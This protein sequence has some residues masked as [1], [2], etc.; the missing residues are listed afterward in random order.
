MQRGQMVYEDYPNQGGPERGWELASGTKSFSGVMAAAAVQDGL[1]DLDERAGETLREWRSDARKRRITIRQILT[2]TSGL[3]GGRLGRPPTYAAAIAAP[4]VAAPGESFSYGPSPFQVF[5]EI[6]RRKTNADPLEYL[7]RRILDPLSIRPTSWRRGAD[8][9]SHLP[10]GAHIIARDWARFGEF[11]LRGGDG[12]VDART[13]RENFEPSRANPG[14]GLTWW[15][16]REGL[17][18]PAERGGGVEIDAALARRVGGI[19]MAAGA[20]DQRLYL[21]PER[22]LVVVRQANRILRS[23]R[24]RGDERWS[25]TDFMRLVLER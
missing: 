8:G 12:R 11:V 2:L 18:P 14:Y 16:W 5:G 17:I 19:S 6:M 10:S 25:D 13:L 3:D 20:G 7:T 1:L 22:G 24:A 23:L 21:V 15:L 9:F 4:A